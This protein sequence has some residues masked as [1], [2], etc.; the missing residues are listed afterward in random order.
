MH[1]EL[2]RDAAANTREVR[3]GNHWGL[4]F[5]ASTRC[6]HALKLRKFRSFKALCTQTP[7]AGFIH[8]APS[9]GSARSGC[10]KCL[11]MEKINSCNTFFRRDLSEALCDVMGNVAFV[12]PAGK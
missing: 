12:L 8:K 6:S 2:P 1:W 11:N 3:R 4:V 7:G 10:Q 5:A 9:L